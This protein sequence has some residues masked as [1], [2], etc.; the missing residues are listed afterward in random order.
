MDV[1]GLSGSPLF[2]GCTPEEIHGVLTCLGYAVRSYPRGAAI[3]NAGETVT[4]IGVV[5]SGSVRIENNDAWGNRSV[6]SMIGPNQIFAEAYAC[7]PGERAMVTVIANEACEVLFLQTGRLFQ[8]G[9]TVEHLP[10]R[11]LQ[12]LITVCARKNLELSHRIFHNASKSIRGRVM[13][14][15]SYQAG[16]Q[17][18]RMVTIPFDRQQLA[19][20]LGTER[21]ALS[22]E[23][24]KMKQDGLLDYHKN[25]FALKGWEPD[26]ADGD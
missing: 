20:Y 19:D 18:K 8:D 3:L 1:T 14:Y 4:A 25:V 23:L 7:V 12:N 2:V 15:L 9:G 16:I 5:R 22:R 13:S 10:G 11:F 21:S 24:A 26:G 6:L 17:G